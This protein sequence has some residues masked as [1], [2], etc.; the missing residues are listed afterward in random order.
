MGCL[1]IPTGEQ[2][3]WYDSR[4]RSRFNVL[5]NRDISHNGFS[6]RIFIGIV[7]LGTHI[8]RS[9][10]GIAMDLH[11][12]VE[13]ELWHL[14][15]LHFADVDVVQW[16]HRPSGSLNL[17]LYDVVNKLLNHLFQFCRGHL[18]T[19]DIDHLLSDLPDLRRLGVMS[20]LR[21]VRSLGCEAD[22]KHPENVSVR[23]LGVHMSLNQCLP[24][25][26]QRSKLVRRQL[27]SIEVRQNTMILHILNAELDE[28]MCLLFV[29]LKIGHTD[30]EDAAL[31]VA[32]RDACSHG[33]GAD[34]AAK[35]AFLEV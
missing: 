9:R 17:F 18:L 6:W 15:H 21:L 35:I 26:D 16:V 29:V 28:T 23:C 22:A 30:T 33:L 14:Q 2:Q 11:E 4:I 31:Q 20:L 32:R 25:A 13:V 5:I 8:L 12:L 19:H 34:G 1:L 7:S 27:N 10:S 24:L 3:S